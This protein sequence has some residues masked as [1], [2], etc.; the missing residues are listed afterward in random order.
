MRTVERLNASSLS[1]TLEVVEVA[2]VAVENASVRFYA[3]K[4]LCSVAD[5]ELQLYKKLTRHTKRQQ[6]KESFVN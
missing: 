3:R 2:M 1:K 6:R 4:R 5:S